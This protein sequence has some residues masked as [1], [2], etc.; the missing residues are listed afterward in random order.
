MTPKTLVPA[1]P[2]PEVPLDWLRMMLTYNGNQID[3]ST[4]PT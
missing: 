1:D 4:N 2:N 3:G